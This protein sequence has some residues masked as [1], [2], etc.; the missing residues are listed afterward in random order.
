[1]KLWQAPFTRIESVALAAALAVTTVLCWPVRGYLTDDTFIHLRYAQHVAMGQGL[2][3]NPGERVYGCTSPLWAALIGDLMLLGLD[4]LFAA[5]LLGFLSTLACVALFL[6]AARRMLRSPLV[7]AGAVLAW[8]THAWFMRWSLSGMETSLA[9]A[10]VLA[11]FVAFTEGERWGARPIRAG[12]LWSLAALARPEAAFLLFLWFAFLLLDARERESIARLFWGTAPPIVIYGSWLLFARLYYG[13][14]WPQTLAAKSAG[15]HG[16][17]FVLDNLSR[18]LRIVGATDG[19]LVILFVAAL[20]FGG[21]R[22]LGAGRS[23]TEEFLVPAWILGLPLLYAA[24]GVQVLSRYLVPVFPLLA[25]SVW[26]ALESWWDPAAPRT[27]R[28]VRRWLFAAV[29]LLISLQNLYVYR[30]A[31]LPQVRS[32]TRGLQESLVPW[33]RWFA[34]HTPPTT[35][36]ATPD[37]GALGY[38]GNRRILDL[39][40]LIT[41]PMVPYLEREEP[42]EVV[43]QFR[44][45]A[46]ARPDYLVDRAHDPYALENRSPY[47]AALIPLGVSRVPNLGLARP[48][49]AY[50]SV[51]RIDWP[52][53]DS[54]A[55]ARARVAPADSGTGVRR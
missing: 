25:L 2:V 21:R 35:V 3:F 37:I 10:L 53:F 41:P 36:I 26:R 20:F 15:G 34:E 40:G 18:Q 5:R 27:S 43:R 42:E 33:G 47:R 14:F 32:F 11:G 39:A 7:R 54:I 8:S 12:T 29:A 23:W 45:A 22:L 38:Y 46:F 50:Y 19:I 44:F 16:T 48:E 31:V 4:G 51:Y 24:R 52:A 13:T 1:M 49:P 30:G 55:T 17:A 28:P 9:T 6:Q